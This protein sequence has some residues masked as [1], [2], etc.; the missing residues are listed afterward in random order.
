[1]TLFSGFLLLLLAVGFPGLGEARPPE[2]VS[3]TGLSAG[4]SGPRGQDQ[5]EAD[6][7]GAE[8]AV[9]TDGWSGRTDLSLANSS[10]NSGSRS[11]GITAAA[12]REVGRFDLSIDGGLLKT[13][14]E[15]VTRQAVG[16]ADSFEVRRR[17]E[18][19]DSADR[20]HLR[21]RMS[22]VLP[23]R[24]R[25]PQSVFE[26]AGWDRDIPAGVL[27]RYELTAGIRGAWGEREEGRAP[28]EVGG[29]LSFVH[30]RDEVEDPEIGAGSFGLRLDVRS[31]HTVGTAEVEVVAGSTWNLSY[32]DDLRLDVTGAVAF[33]LSTRLAFRTSVQT[34]LDTRPAL[35]RVPLLEVIS[36]ARSGT[37]SVR[38][39]RLDL[40]LLAGLALRW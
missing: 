6:S 36:G 9:Q 23:A 38:R 11:I 31:E 28:L 29:G 22:R 14:S 19:R 33:P 12:N 37:V 13:G 15:K 35:V 24:G 5:R 2:V 4:G 25:R 16:T 30:Q 1:M 40:I 32:R 3:S 39:G 26:A 17:V 27:G 10:G 20:T 7:Q 21:A 34:L 18:H 8:S